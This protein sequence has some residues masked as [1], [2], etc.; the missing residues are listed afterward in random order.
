MRKKMAKHSTY[1]F[2]EDARS[3]A[4]FYVQVFGGEILS[5][6]THGDMP[7]AKEDLKDKVLHLSV[8][9]GGVNFLMCDE[10]FNPVQHGNN[11]YQVMEFASDEE[12]HAVFDKL[13]DGGKVLHPLKAEF[14]GSLFGQVEDKF[15]V[16]WMITTEA[17]QQ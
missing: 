6:M 11:I 1:F 14:W 5:V 2:S 8:M 4:A 13:A 3:Q 7:G 17:K 15:G 12:A 16:L 9:A 10:A